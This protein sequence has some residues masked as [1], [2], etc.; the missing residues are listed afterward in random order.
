[1][2]QTIEVLVR[3]RPP[4]TPIQD[5]TLSLD[6][7]QG[8]VYVPRPKNKNQA[9]FTFTRVFGPESDQKSLYLTGCNVIPHVLDGINC[10]IMTYGQTNTG[11]TYT[12]SA[13]H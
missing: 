11:K 1:M 8:K 10:C 6:E 7:E 9:E 2:S 4:N 3:V 13:L 12:V 5:S